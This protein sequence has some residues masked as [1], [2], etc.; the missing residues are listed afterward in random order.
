[1]KKLF[2]LFAA[3]ICAVC[4][5]AENYQLDLT[6]LGSGWESSHDA[7][8]KTITFDGA[9]KGRGWYFESD[10][11]G[12]DFSAYTKVVIETVA[13]AGYAKVVVEYTNGATSSVGEANTGATSIE[14]NLDSDN[15]NDVKQIYIQ[16]GFAGT[17]VLK[18]AYLSQEVVDLSVI[19]EGSA[20]FG[21]NW[22]WDSTIGLSGAAF[23]NIKSGDYIEFEYTINNEQAY[24]QIKA[25]FGQWG[26]EEH[27]MIASMKELKNEYD[28]VSVENETTCISFKLTDEDI[29]TLKSDGLRVSGYDITL[30][31]I[32]STSTPTGISNTI[33]PS[34]A[35]NS[36]RYNLLGVKNGNGIYIMNGKKYMK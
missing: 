34:K 15:S 9:W 12:A 32:R 20:N 26:N 31:K 35:D 7:A 24:H 30:T 21:S 1:M 14:A 11:K 16:A 13:L 18:D 28:C 2:T 23:N 6:N 29:A 4:V 36:V 3:L 33:A 10:G 22:E 19:W 8:T 25:L 27:K 5:N 17:I